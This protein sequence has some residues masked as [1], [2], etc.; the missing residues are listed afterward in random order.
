[1]D[2]RKKTPCYYIFYS[3]GKTFLGSICF[4]TEMWLMSKKDLLSPHLI[5]FSVILR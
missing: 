3:F 5:L 4:F 1:M 2:I